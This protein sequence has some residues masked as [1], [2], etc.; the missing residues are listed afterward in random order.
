MFC[1]L[2][3]C[4]DMVVM[5][6]RCTDALTV[7]T[8]YCSESWMVNEVLELL[9]LETKTYTAKKTEGKKRGNSN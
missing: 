7:V 2:H 5:C 6:I 9:G 3:L 4:Q 8:L 1:Y